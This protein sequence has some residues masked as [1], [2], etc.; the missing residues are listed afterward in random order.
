LT[1]EI[2]IAGWPENR[3]G[4]G[5][6]VEEA[7]I[8]LQFLLAPDNSDAATLAIFQIELAG[9]GEVSDA[10]KVRATALRPTS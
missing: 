1:C 9:K 8:K 4:P 3:R 2:R 7:K 10:M 6:A 5:Q